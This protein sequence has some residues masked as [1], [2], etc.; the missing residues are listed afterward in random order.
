MRIFKKS[1][2]ALKTVSTILSAAQ[3]QVDSERQELSFLLLR[4]EIATSATAA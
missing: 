1:P 2:Q 3:I 4:V